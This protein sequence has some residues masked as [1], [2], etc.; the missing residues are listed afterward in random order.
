V[1]VFISYSRV[2]ET[3]AKTLAQGLTAAKR[4]VWFDHNLAGGDV[5]WDAILRNI[6]LSEVFLFALSDASLHSKPCRLELDY[7]LA[8]RRPILPV[9][10]GPVTSLR[11]NPLAELQIIDYRPDDAQSGFAVLA[12]V[13]EAV[14]RVQVL[15]DP[16][17]AEPPIP[18][19]YLRAL[20][21]EIDSTELSV[22]KQKAVVDQL[23]RALGDETDES[24]RRDILG[25]LRNLDSK[26]FTTKWTQKEIE[27]LL[28]VYG[29][30]RESG[31]S[32]TAPQPAQAATA[33]VPGSSTGPSAG[34]PAAPSAGGNGSPTDATEAV[35][36]AA[37]E[38]DPRDWFAERL[39]QVQRQRRAAEEHLDPDPAPWR[40]AVDAAARWRRTFG[41]T[42]PTGGG[43]W[44]SQQ[45]PS[46]FGATQ[47]SPPPTFGAYGSAPPGQGWA[48]GPG[49]S[50]T[51]PASQQ[52]LPPSPPNYWAMS[53]IAFLL[54]LLFGG[55]AMYFSYQVG[56]RYRAAD[57]E[58]ARKA[59]TRAKV[60]GI[61]GIVVGGLFWLATLPNVG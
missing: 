36:P 30:E 50:A 32:T 43:A 22:D 31:A 51:P 7:A 56:R 6:R 4:D 55:I 8:L 3:V 33:S 49:G 10:V 27:V 44:Q 24:V 28:R 45:Q 16:L 35:G 25:M 61:V 34:S 47:A 26:P 60:W 18:Y 21:R 41:G 1:P 17:P 37:P 39:E 23:R 54:S 20:G 48:P 2:D 14:Q 15:P 38:P 57:L 53:I 46:Y 42:Q 58:G 52:Q 59:S 12:A 19:G 29:P 5:W 40:P 11:A 9:Q 13:D